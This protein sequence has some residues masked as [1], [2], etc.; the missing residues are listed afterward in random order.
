METTAGGGEMKYYFEKLQKK[1]DKYRYKYGNSPRKAALKLT[2][3]NFKCIFKRY[4]K[5][6]E[7][8][9]F[10]VSVYPKDILRIAIAEGGGIGD[11]LIQSTY[12]KEIRK[13]FYN[14]KIIIDFYCHAYK[15]F[16]N[17]P[18]I[19]H[20]YPYNMGIDKDKYDVCLISRRFYIVDKLSPKTKYYSEK[21]YN[22][23]LDC[24]DITDNKLSGEYNDNLYSQYA[25]ILGKNRIEQSNIHNLINV[26]R[27]TPC[28]MQWS[29]DA[30]N[31]LNT[32]NL[33]QNAY[34]TISRNVGTNDSSSHPKLWLYEY[35][36]ELIKF[37][38]KDY[39]NIKIV[40]IGS[41][42][43]EK[44]IKGID[45]NLVGKTTLEEI[46]VLLK[47]AKLHID[48]EG[49][50]VH[51]RHFLY[52]V[53]AVIFGPTKPDIFAY[54]NNINCHSSICPFTCEWVTRNW[55]KK[56]INQYRFHICMKDLKPEF[57]YNKINDYLKNEIEWNLVVDEMKPL[58]SIKNKNV[59][60]IG[61][62]SDYP[63]IIANNNVTIF[64]NTVVGIL[65]NAEY[66]T[67]YNISS[68][69][70][71][72]DFVICKNLPSSYSIYAFNE[73]VR[74]LKEDGFL[75]LGGKITNE[76]S[77]KLNI[78]NL[79][80]DYISIKKIRKIL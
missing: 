31:I 24:K 1:I 26:D 34:I 7:N 60:I 56:C 4:S 77:K 29:L 32:Y 43:T 72:F 15:L 75:L 16:Q 37:I 67:P 66:S 49:G 45:I 74:I 73:L 23:C 9:E 46:K 80:G 35:Y 41:S 68:N 17:F 38:K 8:S 71:S 18:F 36:N 6:Q 44:I 59:A 19:D 5:N 30:F 70:I 62:A 39:P 12:I 27:Y 48:I 58:N 50:M 21:F 25:L 3:W 11:A 65:K 47:Y 64:D 63:E 14:K 13:L 28:Y 79:N 61:D 20:T 2:W 33:D 40:Q 53:S 51:L 57:V 69:N 52:G 76:L 54:D 78:D 10:I 55:T 42:D 22:F